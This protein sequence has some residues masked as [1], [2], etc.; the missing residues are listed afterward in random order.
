M[1]VA[2]ITGASRGIGK[3]IC[4]HLALRGYSIAVTARSVQD[5]DV[6]PYPGTIME[7]A[8]LVESL[9]GRAL[10]IRCDVESPAD[11]RDAVQRTLDAFGRID[12]L[13]NNARYEGPAHWDPFTQTDWKE[14][15]R[16]ISTNYRGPM[17]LCHLVVPRMV[18]QG[19]G[20]IIHIASRSA[21]AENPNMPG[22]GST[23]LFYPSSKA[24]LDRMA[25][26]LAKE[27][28]TN[29]IAVIGLSPG[30]TLT[31]RATAGS[32]TYGY[33]LSRRHSVHVPA[34]A[35]DLLVHCPDPLVFT[36]RVLEAPDFVREHFLM[37]PE[38]MET[39]FRPGQLYDPY[40][41]PYWLRRLRDA[42]RG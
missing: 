28:R 11:L 6:T 4:A 12:L 18:E 25:V 20:V 30:A 35:L 15:E 5:R 41:E 14:V 10:P 1:K 40:K 33:D 9:G 21:Q 23:S 27:V 13:I 17:L 3:A 32:E 34:A 38:E 19:G 37:E 2:F 26:G 22:K 31:E 16:L 42:A 29:G 8:N 39:P 36:G 24:G 7:T